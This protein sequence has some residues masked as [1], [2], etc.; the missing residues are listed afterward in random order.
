MRK[1]LCR[2]TGCQPTWKM[3][4]GMAHIYDD[5]LLW[6]TLADS[7]ELCEAQCLAWPNCQ[8]IDFWTPADDFVSDITYE[9]CY[10][11]SDQ[12]PNN[13]VYSAEVDHYDLTQPTGNCGTYKSLHVLQHH[14]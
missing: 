11:Y 4:S 13:L 9:Q 12:K 3:S 14:F 7:V 1:L 8:S 6:A 5:S 2:L 10:L